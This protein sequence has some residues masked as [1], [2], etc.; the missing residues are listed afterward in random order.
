MRSVGHDSI[1][2]LFAVAI[3]TA[4]QSLSAGQPA[5][6][7]ADAS[8][9]ESPDGWVAV[10][11]RLIAGTPHYSVQYRSRALVRGS[12][13]GFE[14]GLVRD[15][16]NVT[17]RQSE[18]SGDWINPFGERRHVPDNYRQLEVEL[19]HATGKL[20]R[21]TFRAYNEGAALRYTLPSQEKNTFDVEAEHTEFRFAPDTWGYEEHGTEGEYVR[22][23]VAEFQPWCERPLTLEFAGGSFASLGEAGNSAYP[24]MLVS[25]LPGVPGALVSALGGPTSNG[26]R[27]GVN[28]GQAQL[29]AGKSTPWRYLIVGDSPGELVERN[30]LPLNLNAPSAIA[31]TSWI[32]PGKAMRDAALTTASAKAIID[33]A[34]RLGLDYVGF[35]AHWYGNDDGGDVTHVRAPNLNIKEVADYAKERDVRVCIYV[36]ARQMKK[37]QEEIFAL[38]QDWGVDAL[39]IG[40]VTVGPQRETTWLSDV[41][42]RAAEN[43]LVLDVHDGYRAT[44][45]ERTYP[46]LLTVEGIRGNEHM[47]TPEH[48][49]VL[50]FT[51]FLGGSGDYTVCYLDRRLQTTHAHQ[52]AMGLVA[53]S[54][55]QWLYWYD[56]PSQFSTV[57]PELEFW[58]H[59]PTVWDMTKV[60]HGK[61]GQY[62]TLARQ[63]GRDWFVGTI[64]NSQPRSLRLPLT[65]LDDSKSYTAHLYV[66]D[67][68]A[69]TPTKVAV[70]TRP[71]DAMTV[72]DV[73]LKA[74]GGQAL[75]IEAGR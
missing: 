7:A 39:K 57:P 45:I 74:G 21:I 73:E 58:V 25:P 34:P 3:A 23:K 14:P 13:I 61:I 16:T 10:Q 65:F 53:F 17:F 1:A 27:G 67:D 35:D 22:A 75:W 2:V 18:H 29:A 69:P 15:F 46:N 47:P 63:C 19:K 62:A 37:Q 32:H 28:D 70:Q 4:S 44:G 30:Y 54:P 6:P 43:R 26:P 38:C 41:I 42:K 8:R 11:F 12:Q 52:L 64:N 68:A 48:N 49:C 72:L 66:D 50:P 9:V 20:L 60:I 40:F 56:R 36:D 51:R 59:M 71:V 55:M 5:S 33:L 31:K 24:R